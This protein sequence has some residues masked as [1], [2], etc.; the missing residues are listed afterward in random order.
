MVLFVEFIGS[1]DEC[2][3]FFGWWVVVFIV[4]IFFFGVGGFVLCNVGDD[5]VIGYLLMG[6]VFGIV[7][8]V[9]MLI[10]FCMVVVVV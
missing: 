5:L 1:Y 2:I 8:G 4:V 10:V 9:G 3:W 6:I 7:I